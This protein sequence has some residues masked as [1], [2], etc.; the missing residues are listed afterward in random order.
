MRL[1]PTTSIHELSVLLGPSARGFLE[2]C[3][4]RALSDGV[5]P[6]SE[7]R[8]LSDL[9]DKPVID[10]CRLWRRYIGPRYFHDS[11]IS[12]ERQ[13]QILWQLGPTLREY[14]ARKQACLDN[15]SYEWRNRSGMDILKRSKEPA[16][17]AVSPTFSALG[18]RLQIGFLNF[19][20]KYWQN[21]D[22]IGCYNCGYFAS[23]IP[24]ELRDSWP[25]KSLTDDELS[26]LLTEQFIS[27]I[28]LRKGQTEDY[29]VIDFVSDGSFLNKAEVPRKAQLAILAYIGKDLKDTVKRVLIETRTEYV[30]KDWVEL[31]LNRLDPDQK[32]T[33]AIGLETSDAFVSGFCINK[34]YFFRNPELFVTAPSKSFEDVVHELESLGDRVEIQA[35]VLVKPAFLVEH[36]ALADAINTVCRINS[37]LVNKRITV[38]AK[39]EPTVV[40]FGSLLDVLYDTTVGQDGHLEV[41]RHSGLDTLSETRSSRLYCS[42]SY[43]TVAELFAAL[44]TMQA[45][46]I[47]RI[48]AR[49]DMDVYREI[50]GV[51]DAG[52]LSPVDAV[53]YNVIQQLNN[54]FHTG[55]PAFVSLLTVVDMLTRD[56][57][58]SK[59]Q[60]MIG[61]HIPYLSRLCQQFETSILKERVEM[62]LTGRATSLRSLEQS[63]ADVYGSSPVQAIAAKAAAM[64]MNGVTFDDDS[65]LELIKDLQFAIQPII[66]RCFGRTIRMEISEFGLGIGYSQVE[67]LHFKIRLHS[68][69]VIETPRHANTFDVWTIIPSNAMEVRKESSMIKPELRTEI[70]RKWVIDSV[71]IE[72]LQDA[73]PYLQAYIAISR[74]EE[75]RI[76][77]RRRRGMMSSQTGDYEYILTCKRGS[78][79]E[80]HEYEINISPDDFQELFM[81]ANGRTIEKDRYI[82]N[83]TDPNLRTQH[84]IELDLYKSGLYGLA[85]AEVEFENQEKARSFSP[86]PW[87]GADVTLDKRFKN[88][89]LATDGLDAILLTPDPRYGSTIALLSDTL[90]DEQVQNI[91]KLLADSRP[92]L[93]ILDIKDPELP[94]FATRLF[95]ETATMIRSSAIILVD[96]FDG[97]PSIAAWM[98][99]RKQSGDPLVHVP[100]RGEDWPLFEEEFRNMLAKEDLCPKGYLLN[101][102]VKLSKFIAEQ[103]YVDNDSLSVFEKQAKVVNVITTTLEQDTG[104]LED[105]VLGQ[106]K[107]GK[108]YH[109]Y[110]PNL[111]RGGMGYPEL[112][113]NIQKFRMRFKDYRDQIKFFYMPSTHVPYYREM[114][115][116]DDG[117]YGFTYIEARD[118]NH[119]LEMIEIPKVLLGDVIK[120][121]Q[122]ESETVVVI[123]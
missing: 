45:F 92:D 60:S 21:S 9:H 48:G 97:N 2:S 91:R 89:S 40:C 103:C 35:Y 17:A 58:F 56:G 50:P 4:L 14:R 98:A 29:D 31:L 68:V 53:L 22:N 69:A 107:A 43:W 73:N 78:D 83:Y 95:F 8:S 33:I 6:E 110:I 109:Y 123:P 121:L 24:L 99:I 27:E 72:L 44:Y 36:E 10:L 79:L 106:L 5:I 104:E 13:A 118:L 42:P 64:H 37:I 88:Q 85:T 57:S 62:E 55:T 34:G 46:K 38:Y 67:S 63:L 116:Y 115:I 119:G 76:R 59:W 105:M 94:V 75:V 120:W 70:E 41:L 26:S 12:V 80:R 25:G 84:K 108:H 11:V 74:D 112:Q 113:N 61:K 54:S 49:E 30:D 82:I 87:F 23:C 66:N 16:W 117:E 77:K 111:K 19:G 90:D 93:E 52:R 1:E 101:G 96:D 100:R 7:G 47:C 39:L 32:L 20:C 114:V 18:S 86:P 3:F 65:K 102:G 28:R 51:Y 71:P 81:G 122:R 15:M